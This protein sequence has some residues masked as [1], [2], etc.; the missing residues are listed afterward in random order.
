MPSHIQVQGVPDRWHEAEAA[1]RRIE[2]LEIAIR[3]ALSFIQE[4]H[5]DNGTYSDGHAEMVAMALRGAL[6]PDRG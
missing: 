5:C 1:K 6:K 3:A 4:R 2:E